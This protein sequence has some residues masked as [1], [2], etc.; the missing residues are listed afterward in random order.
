M[1]N[2]KSLV[3]IG[4]LIA[5]VTIATISIKIPMPGTG[6]YIHPGDTIIYI[7]AILFGGKYAL[8]AG[9]LG[10]AL[11]DLLSGYGQWALPT[12]LIKGLE[13]LIIAKIANQTLKIRK[14]QFRDVLAIL[15]GALWM[16]MGYYLAEAILVKSFVVPLAS[17]SWNLIQA[18][19]GGVIAFPILFALLK[20][21][22]TEF[23]DDI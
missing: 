14:L 8:L 7:V 15:G 20:T 17:I 19:G 16:V 18:I 2:T 23:G 13:G 22:I 1:K 21:N 3:L 9:G 11:A 5:L 10:S 4:L 12:L 6:G